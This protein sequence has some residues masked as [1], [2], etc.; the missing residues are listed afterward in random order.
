MFY[1]GDIT[2]GQF[3]KTHIYS[4]QRINIPGLAFK[5]DTTYEFIDLRSQSK[6]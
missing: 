3:L 5:F 2:P 4:A 6:Q 1:G